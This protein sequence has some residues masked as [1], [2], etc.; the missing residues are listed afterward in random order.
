MPRCGMS[1]N[2]KYNALRH[3]CQEIF[4]AKRQEFLNAQFIDI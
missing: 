2:G 1:D 3:D 4:A